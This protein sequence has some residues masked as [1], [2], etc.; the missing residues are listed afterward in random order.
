M[1]ALR[2]TTAIGII[3]AAIVA[4]VILP[5]TLDLFLSVALAS[6]A[7]WAGFQAGRSRP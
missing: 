1:G 2:S 5:A 6:A 7:G 3:G 4:Q